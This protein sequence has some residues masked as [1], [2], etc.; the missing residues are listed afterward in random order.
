MTLRGAAIEDSEATLRVKS[1]HGDNAAGTSALP[2]KA[3]I[4]SQRSERPQW[5]QELP[6]AVQQNRVEKAV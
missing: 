3:D 2:P 4:A 6:R 5:G 1:S